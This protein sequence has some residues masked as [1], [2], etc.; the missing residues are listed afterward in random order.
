MKPVILI[1]LALSLL[2]VFQTYFHCGSRDTS[3][4]FC[5][6]YASLAHC[7]V[8]LISQE[9]ISVGESAM[10]KYSIKA[11]KA[12]SESTLNARVAFGGFG[13]HLRNIIRDVAKQ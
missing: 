9:S 6:C 11:G 3:Y 5:Y 10:P 7:V 2:K 12:L 13:S 4:T 8:H 1:K